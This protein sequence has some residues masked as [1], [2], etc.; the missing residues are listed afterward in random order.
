[1]TDIDIGVSRPASI[2]T[3]VTLVV[4]PVG[5]QA[6][7]VAPNPIMLFATR[8]TALLLHI[9]S[10]EI[11]S[12]YTAEANS[13]PV[14]HMAQVAAAEQALGKTNNLSAP[15]D[16]APPMVTLELESQTTHKYHIFPDISRG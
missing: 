5:Y 2:F 7:L 11:S 13:L 10:A 6:S 4:C 1:M 8:E 12:N 9:R 15:G 16:R 3:E 14:L